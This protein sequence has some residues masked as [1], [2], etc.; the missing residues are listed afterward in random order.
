MTARLQR[1]LDKAEA[2]SVGQAPEYCQCRFD[3]HRAIAAIAPDPGDRPPT[4][5]C[6]RCGRP[7]TLRVFC[8]DYSPTQ[9]EA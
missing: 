3:Y 8:Y 2:Q 7:F 9:A 5:V 6:D 4:D 1:R